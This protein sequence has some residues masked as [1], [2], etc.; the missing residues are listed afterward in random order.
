MHTLESHPSA[1]IS[2]RE[3]TLNA[4]GLHGP[5]VEGQHRATNF[6]T[7]THDV[8]GIDI[9]FPSLMMSRSR[10]QVNTAYYDLLWG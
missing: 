9:I 7:V 2:D 5:P 8:N 3:S 10:L 6:S 4:T 1:E